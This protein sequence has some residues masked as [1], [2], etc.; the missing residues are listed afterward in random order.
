[1][2]KDQVIKIAEVQLLY[3]LKKNTAIN[4]IDL[5]QN[6][7]WAVGEMLNIIIGGDDG[8]ESRTSRES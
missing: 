7:I 8:T 6:E 5:C 2:T 4:L 3:L 1:M